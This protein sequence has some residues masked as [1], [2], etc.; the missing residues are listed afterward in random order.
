MLNICF[1]ARTGLKSIE[2]LVVGGLGGAGIQYNENR[3][4]QSFLD[5]KGP[6]SSYKTNMLLVN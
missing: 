1:L 4:M 2:D 3:W 5:A 6:F